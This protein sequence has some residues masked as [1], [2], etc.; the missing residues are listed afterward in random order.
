GILIFDSYGIHKY[1]QRKDIRVFKI[2]AMDAAV[3]MK[4]GKA[5]NMII[6]GGL[7]KI[8]PM[9]KYENVIAGLKKSLPERHHKL[10]PMNEQAIRKGMEIVTEVTV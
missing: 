8:K 3:E 5:F 4:N 2:D 10:I 7:L 6:L 1:P 9:V